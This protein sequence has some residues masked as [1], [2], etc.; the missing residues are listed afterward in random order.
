MHV[1]KII[2]FIFS[3]FTSISCVYSQ[4]QLM[5]SLFVRD[6]LSGERIQ[7][8]TKNIL[9]IKSN[10]RKHI[11][12]VNNIGDGEIVLKNEKTHELQTINIS[13]IEEIQEVEL[14]KKGS[15]VLGWFNIVFSSIFFTYISYSA[16]EQISD[17]DVEIGVYG[18]LGSLA[19]NSLILNQGLKKYRGVKGIT[20]KYS[21]GEGRL[22]DNTYIEGSRWTLIVN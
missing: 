4:N 12:F 3:I 9:Y 15:K 20:R 8:S 11:G 14:R 22:I 19:L 10:G 2:I 13:D 1:L 21:V 7:I 5:D 6:N 18:L 16:I 17:G